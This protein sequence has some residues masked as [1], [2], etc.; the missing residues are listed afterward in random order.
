MLLGLYSDPHFSQSSSILI[1]NKGILSKRLVNLIESFD[2]MNNLFNSLKVDMVICLGDLTDKP[3]LTAEEITAMSKC[4]LENHIKL[5]GN[6]C[7]S[8]KDGR[9][10]AI[11]TFDHVIDTPG[12]LEDK[13]FPDVP[14]YKNSGI[15]FLP[16]N[17]ELIDLS[18]ISPRPKVILSHN[19]IKGYDF[20]GIKSSSGYALSDILQSCDLFINGHLHNGG[21]LVK[22]RIMN[23]GC[24]TGMNFSSTGGEW[25]SSVIT[26]DTETLEIRRYDNPQAFKFRKCEFDTLP[27]LKGYLDNLRSS[28]SRNYVLQVKVPE[29]IAEDA[30]KLLNQSESVEAS[31]VLTVKEPSSHSDKIEVFKSEPKTVYEKF[32]DFIKTKRTSYSQEVIN[33]IIDKISEKGVQE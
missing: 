12:F 8:D 4:Y 1:G 7:R 21:W 9:I 31:R 29:K 22:D 18:T 15:Y 6:H 11:S 2:W 26:L 16:Y 33:S 14:F 32:S 20:G 27:K 28:N 17:S 10:N 19:D 23:I 30:R 25:D 3:V 24:L 13:L 5:L